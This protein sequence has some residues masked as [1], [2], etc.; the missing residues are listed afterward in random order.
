M[1]SLPRRHHLPS[2]LAL[3][4]WLCCLAPL[5][6][7]TLPSQL[8]SGAEPGRAP[9]RPLLPTPGMSAPPVSVPQASAAQAPAGAEQLR[10]TLREW[11]IEGHTAFSTESLQPLYADLVGREITVARAFEAANAIELR[12]RNAGYVT[13]RVIVPAQAIEDGRF[14]VVVVEGFI[15]RIELRGDIGAA[16]AAVERLLAPLRGVRPVSV[17]EIE[18][19]LLIANDIPGLTVRATLEPS[20]TAQGA[21][22]MVVQVTRD[23][24]DASWSIDNR[25]S[26]YLGDAQ[27]TGTVAW[28]AL[29]T[30]ATR[31][32]L[33]GR[34]SVPLNRSQYVGA[35]VDTLL[36]ANGATLGLAASAARSHP[37]RELDV[38]DVRSRVGAAS[39]TLTYPLI[40][41]REQNLRAVGQF[42]ARDV[43]TDITGIAFTR[44]R[45]RIAR[46]GLSYDRTDSHDGITA[47]RGTLHRG[48]DGLGAT[49]NGNARA[50]RPDGRIDFFKLTA[51]ATRLQQL[52][53]RWSLLATVAAQ[54][55]ADPLLASEEMGLGGA[56]F[57]RGY[58]E[59]E[60]SGDSGIA[61]S[62]ELRYVLPRP[63]TAPAWL[64]QL[65]AYG[66]A[67][68][69]RVRARAPKPAPERR[70]L[71]SVGG[72]LRAAL[73]QGLFAT[74]EI[75]QPT[76]GDVKT[77]DNKHPR[78][79]VSLSARY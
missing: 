59:G 64:Q 12:Y 35:N 13:S 42:E 16:Q 48:L 8:P 11:V 14:R 29:G 74:I 78:V 76:S 5:A 70:T 71:S 1:P 47:L 22:A 38:L 50:S 53:Q 60:V 3:A 33:S 68:G 28:N 17:A 36:G 77:R 21:S 55:S 15:D 23:E 65:Q 32:S 63:E 37:G 79:F 41:S 4:A 57:G 26:P 72:G 34:V 31:L 2:T 6:A 73:G 52:G 18:R 19:R 56:S 25:N 69:G 58:D 27:A 61:A 44:D 24:V 67:D 62:V 75:A 9:A 54:L 30:Q 39:A 43:A 66:F 45:L 49:D 20:A 40:R 10:F 7:Q 51:E 46:F